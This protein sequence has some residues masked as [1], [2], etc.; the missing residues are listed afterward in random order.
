MQPESSARR[1]HGTV[2][3]FARPVRCYKV[4][5]AD[6]GGAMDVMEG[7]CDPAGQLVKTAQHRI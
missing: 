6:S 2:K 7:G 5:S 4:V 3:L 1:G